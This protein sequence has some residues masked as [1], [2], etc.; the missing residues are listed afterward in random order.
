MTKISINDILSKKGK[1]KIT[2]L[3][4]YTFPIAKI[5]DEFCDITLVGDSLGMA[6]YGLQDTVDVS[7]A[8]MINHAKAVMKAN[9]KSLVVVDIPA[10]SFEESAKQALQ[11]AKEIVAKSGCDAVKI[12]TSENE[13][14]AIKLIA[15]SGINIMAHVGLLPQQVRKLGGYKYQG[16]TPQEAQKIIEIAKNAEKAG[17]FAI[18][19]EAVP[20]WLGDEI[21]AQLKIPTI[22]I[23]ASKNCDGQILVIDDILGLNQEFT[24]KFVKNYANLGEIVKNAV[25]NYSFEVKSEIFPENKHML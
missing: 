3:T 5:V 13:I 23:G 14:A 21:T 6:I 11:T 15:E 8:M 22:G 16:K 20:A 19:I 17:A 25:K 4:A 18:V 1:E 2:C 24:P 10:K 7:V 12:E 9:K